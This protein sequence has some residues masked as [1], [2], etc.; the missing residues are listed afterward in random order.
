M[1]EVPTTSLKMLSS[2]FV[3]HKDWDCLDVDIQC[4]LCVMVDGN[5][6]V[7][8]VVEEEL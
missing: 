1:E 6:H 5:G 2:E 8:A 4:C 3:L 7:E